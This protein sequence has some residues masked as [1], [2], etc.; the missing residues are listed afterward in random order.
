MEVIRIRI[1]S[2]PDDRYTCKIGMEMMMMMLRKKVER[3]F[4]E[5]EEEEE[6]E[7]EIE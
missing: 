3:G 1:R 2:D 5:E 6:E 4:K 7:E